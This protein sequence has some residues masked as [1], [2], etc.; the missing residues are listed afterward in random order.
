MLLFIQV[1]QYIGDESV[2]SPSTLGHIDAEL[3][4]VFIH[5]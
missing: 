4:A 3:Q 5:G 1:E 2:A